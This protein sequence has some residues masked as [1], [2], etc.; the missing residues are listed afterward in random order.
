MAEQICWPESET[1]YIRIK[2]REIESYITNDFLKAFQAYKRVKQYGWPQGKGY[3]AEPRTLFSIVE[4]FDSEKS[5][6][7]E[8]EKEKKNG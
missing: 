6:Y 2:R 3:L 1:G 4:L 8:W 7:S 5:N